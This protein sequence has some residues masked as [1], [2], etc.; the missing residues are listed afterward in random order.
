MVTSTLEQLCILYTDL[1]YEDISR[2]EEVASTLQLYADMSDSYM[3]IDC[4]IKDNDHAIVV[5][6]AFP[7]NANKIYENSVVG[8]IVFESFE[9]GV[10][11]SYKNGKKSIIRQ[12]ITQEGKSVDQTVV[13][14]KNNFHQVI[15][16]LIQEKEVLSKMMYDDGYAEAD[17]SIV[18]ARNGEFLASAVGGPPVVSDLLMEMLI[19]TDDKDQLIYTNPVALNFISEMSRTEEV[20]NAKITELL[21]FLTPVYDNKEDVFVFDLTIDRK[22]LVV[23]KIKLKKKDRGETLLIIQDLTELRMKEKELMMKSVVIQEIHHRVKN[24]LQTIAS[25][26]RLQMRGLPEDSQAS[27][28]DTLN[29]IYSISSVY[30]IILAKEHADDDDVNIIELTRKICSAMVLNDVSSKVDL[31]IQ[32]NGNK[33]ITSS[34]KAVSLAIIVNE[35]VQNS[36]KHAFDK[37][38][39]GE[40]R[41]WFTSDRDFLELHISDNGVGMKEPKPSLGTEIVH[42]LVT[43]DLNGEF[44]YVPQEEGTHAV[45]TFPVSPEVEIFYEKEDINS[46][47]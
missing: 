42:N 21:P 9:P 13:P 24:N 5:A 33:I 1:T 16:V 28:E 11:Y 17:L 2:L 12:A 41:I 6:E 40:I 46:R 47:R 19:L 30:E 3:F 22:S 29:R 37:E 10:F 7:R 23:K 35:L 44:L 27:F 43:N 39:E 18:P 32:P 14:I 38:G 8:K 20:G 25:L 15:G 36:L 4:K 45:V 34:R 31:I 26:L